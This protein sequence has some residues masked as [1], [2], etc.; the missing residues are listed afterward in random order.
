MK[1]AA[2]PGEK[3]DWYGWLIA[4]RELPSWKNPR[5]WI[6]SL[7]ERG[8]NLF[9]P[10]NE[11]LDPD[12]Q[13]Y[14]GKKPRGRYEFVEFSQAQEMFSSRPWFSSESPCPWVGQ[15]RGFINLEW[16]TPPA[17]REFD[18]ERILGASMGFIVRLR[19]DRSWDLSTKNQYA[20]RDASLKSG[21]SDGDDLFD[22]GEEY[23]EYVWGEIARALA[24]IDLAAEK[25]TYGTS[26]NRLRFD[27]LS[28]PR[29]LSAEECRRR[30]EEYAEEPL[31]IWAYNNRHEDFRALLED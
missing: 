25:I 26:H 7:R 10:L 23:D 24:K 16:W 8:R 17:D 9:F 11:L 13:L 15:T 28:S 14:D 18:A 21:F 20:L 22:L 27:V 1:Y 19:D 12:G 31:E 2:S 3:R 4:V 30:F 5:D 6:E 29:G